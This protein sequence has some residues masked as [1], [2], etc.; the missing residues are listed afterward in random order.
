MKKITKAGIGLAAVAAVATTGALVAF[1]TSN[2]KTFDWNNPTTEVV[3][4]S[5]YNNAY[6]GD[7]RDFVRISAYNENN[8]DNVWYGDKLEM[9]DGMT[10]DNMYSVRLLVHNDAAGFNGEAGATAEDVK[11]VSYLNLNDTNSGY[12]GFNATQNVYGEVTAKG[13]AGLKENGDRLEAVFDEAR[14]VDKDGKKFKLELVP[15]SV[16]YWTCNDATR[17]EKGNCTSSK[18]WTISDAVIG[19]PQLLGYYAMDGKIPGCIG[20]AGYLTYDVKAVYEQE[21]VKNPGL[22]VEKS[23]A[24]IDENGNRVSDYYTDGIQNCDQ[25]NIESCGKL[26]I[27]AGDRLRFKFLAT[28]TGDTNIMVNM[29]DNLPA[30]L[31]YIDNTTT[32]KAGADERVN[33]DDAKYGRLVDQATGGIT[34][35]VTLAPGAKMDFTIDVQVSG[36][37]KEDCADYL[38]NNTVHA[39][40]LN[41]ENQSEIVIETNDDVTVVI[42]SDKVCTEGYHLDKMARVNENDK[43]AKTVK[44]QAG[45]IVTYRIRFWNDGNTDLND[46]IIDDTQLDKNMTYI[47]GSTKMEYIQCD[48]AIASEDNLCYSV[49]DMISKDDGITNGGINVGT[50]AGGKT[51]AVYFQAKVNDN[52][53]GKCEKTDLPN[54]V[55]GK[56]AN[57]TTG[58]SS[59]ALVYVDGVECHEDVTDFTIDKM[60]QKDGEGEWHEQVSVKPGETVR[61]RIVFKNTGN[62][63]L[64]NVVISDKL[65]DGLNLVPETVTV[66]GL[67]GY[68]DN[69]FTK[70]GIKYASIPAGTEITIF[71]KATVSSDYKDDCYDTKLPN[72]AKAQDETGKTKQD[73]ADVISTGK[74]C[75]DTPD[76]PHTGTKD[77]ISIATAL[78]GVSTAAAY[79]IVSRKKN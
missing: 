46:V 21:E 75:E 57:D 65:V 33:W 69:G 55:I 60:V 78:A 10:K 74:V 77:V 50:I 54:L 36:N 17:N 38:I 43:W 15:G 66:Q 79:Y 8:F 62:T 64:K 48:S 19:N 39:F 45:D 24:I 28:N 4:N 31:S 30:S 49:S 53:A 26:E 29:V 32:Y 7:E 70:G 56:H 68:E 35:N 11:A 27:K 42:P 23:V 2:Q 25:N 5:Y 72:T 44:A 34:P 20:Y 41:P 3:F 59:S 73:D 61:Y 22:S 71:F 47:A 13:G 40:A 37:A 18:E 51:I 67:E 9:Y 1:G 12:N 6:F 76:L 14:F 63:E 58:Q 52:L 16:R